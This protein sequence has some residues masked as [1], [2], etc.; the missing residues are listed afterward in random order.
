MTI[1]HLVFDMGGVLVELQWLDRVKNLLDSPMTLEDLHK[2]WVSALSTTDFETGCSDFDAFTAAFIQEFGLAI[3]PD[4]LQHEFLEIVQA[5][6]PQCNQVLSAL[7]PRYHLSLLS[8]TNPAHYERLRDRYNFFD[9]FDQ[10]FL[11]YKI[12]GMKPSAA[13]FKHLLTS[14]DTPADTVVFFDDG[15]RNVEAARALGIHAYRVESPAAVM[16][17]VE[18]FSNPVSPSRL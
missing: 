1:T 6:L 5:P 17:V 8:N 12:G 11:S 14:L 2:L 18:G 4:V 16:A 15:A 7:K 9:Y 13:I 10:I 3:A